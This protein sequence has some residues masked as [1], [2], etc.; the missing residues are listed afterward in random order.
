MNPQK[1][2]KILIHLAPPRSGH[3]FLKLN[4]CSW[5]GI[6]YRLNYWNFEGVSPSQF[7]SRLKSGSER[8]ERKYARLFG[9]RSQKSQSLF[10]P[11]VVMNWRCPKSSDSM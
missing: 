11:Y 2:K 1:D 7:T 9:K 4:L 8:M 3:N 6:D 5:M 10:M